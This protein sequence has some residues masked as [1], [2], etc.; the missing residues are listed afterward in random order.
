MK[1]TKEP[2]AGGRVLVVVLFVFSVGEKRMRMRVHPLKGVSWSIV[3][4]SMAKALPGARLAPLGKQPKPPVGQTWFC[5]RLGKAQPQAISS[6]GRLYG[7]V[8]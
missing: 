1:R 4:W 8:D 7:K 5:S 3:A 2:Q 6:M